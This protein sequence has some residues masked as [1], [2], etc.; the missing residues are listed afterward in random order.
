MKTKLGKRTRQTGKK[1]PIKGV[2]IELNSQLQD[3]I[4]ALKNASTKES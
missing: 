4:E 3:Y 1:N 2:L